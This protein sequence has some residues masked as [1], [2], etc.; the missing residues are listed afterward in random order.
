MGQLGG[1]MSAENITLSHLKS[2][3]DYDPDT[4]R[5]IHKE[6]HGLHPNRNVKYAGKFADTCVDKDGYRSVF[7]SGI[8]VRVRAHRLAWFYHYGTHPS[9][10]IDHI[11]GQVDDNRICNLREATIVENR[12]NS[13]HQDR[14][15]LSQRGISKNGE[16]GFRVRVNANGEHHYIGTFKKLEDAI[17]ARDDAHLKFYGSYARLPEELPLETPLN[18][19]GDE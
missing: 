11:N 6:V 4:G 9:G 5:F 14:N 2:V 8:K 18:A 12:W 3:L 1:F 19:I 10:N 17:K 13:R 16:Y 7:I 15:K